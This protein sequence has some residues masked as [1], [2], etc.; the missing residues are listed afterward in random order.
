MLKPKGGEIFITKTINPQSVME[1]ADTW[2]H[3]N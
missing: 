1:K 3:E 2:I